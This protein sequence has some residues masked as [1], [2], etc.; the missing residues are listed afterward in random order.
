[1]SYNQIDPAASYR[2]Y[3]RLGNV[4]QTIIGLYS[5]K[6]Y[7]GSSG[8]GSR[9]TGNE[10]KTDAQGNFELFISKEKR[11][12]NWLPMTDDDKSLT[13]YQIFGDWE[14]ENKGQLLL[15]RID[16]AGVRSDL[17]SEQAM[18]NRYAAFDEGIRQQ[19]AIWLNIFSRQMAAPANL[20]QPPAIIQVASKG[21]YFSA[22]HWQVKEDEALV[23]EFD[24]PAA[25]RYW[26]FSC[27]NV[28]S[29]LLDPAGRQTSLNFTQAKK[30]A[31]GKYRIVMSATRYRRLR[32]GWILR[33]IRR[34]LLIGV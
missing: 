31:D 25:A 16:T 29:D 12:D 6:A 13:I 17:P 18:K 23:I 8:A 19:I 20:F 22:M 34:V 4:N 21:S 24:D 33:A 5:P 28:W 10:I 3:G 1:M 11:G 27:Y 7:Q 15:E 14:K 9:I 2:L 26:S 30:G 32:T